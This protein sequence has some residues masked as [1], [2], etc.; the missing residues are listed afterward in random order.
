MTTGRQ[1][2]PQRVRI[3]DT[4]YKIVG[5]V[6][7][8]LAS[9]FPQKLV[10]GDYS[11][12]SHPLV[13][14]I[15]WDDWRGGMLKEVGEFPED[16]HRTYYTSL[17]TRFKGHAFLPT[18]QIS[19]P[20]VTFVDSAVQN[21]TFFDTDSTWKADG[22]VY[23]DSA[24]W[25]MRPGIA[26]KNA[27]VYRFSSA[28]TEIS[29][30][31]ANGVGGFTPTSLYADKI[32][33]VDFIAANIQG[34]F[35]H[36]DGSM[37][38]DSWISDNSAPIPMHTIRWKDLLWGVTS[39]GTIAFT[40]PAAGS[41]WDWTATTG[42]TEIQSAGNL[43]NGPQGMEVG[44]DGRL[45]VMA[46]KGIFRYDSQNERVEHVFR[47]P[48]GYN[49]DLPMYVAHTVWQG[50][51]FYARGQ[52]MWR[53]T[54]EGG[55]GQPASAVAMGLD[56]D[57]G[58]PIT[59][60]GTI[61]ALGHVTDRLIAVVSPTDTSAGIPGIYSWDEVRNAWHTWYL[62]N[63]TSSYEGKVRAGRGLYLSEDRINIP[64]SVTNTVNEFL[65]AGFAADSRSLFT[66]YVP[67]SSVATGVQHVVPPTRTDSNR[68][69]FT[70]DS[71]AEMIL[72]WV[73][74]T[75]TKHGTLL[76]LRLSTSG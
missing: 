67:E 44:P 47:V 46:T 36:R 54:P 56:G 75:G 68:F 45:Y 39:S 58:L 14:T 52:E 71:L 10:I 62:P 19:S 1:D 5:G 64:L 48:G 9:T 66:A 65:V 30:S 76:M 6:Q 40:K 55:F 15:N 20:K 74:R 72:P 43:A 26:G 60:N 73:K 3:D 12:E 61:A 4:N 28:G 22:I 63:V 53:W 24:L 49:A 38:N 37:A 27:E 25:V 33:S 13:S 32:D 21:A 2:E 51:I 35:Y 29:L 50:S 8:S 7:R 57:D 23:G 31:S 70:K 69:A 11:Q 34:V 16:Q 17:N 18:A 42:P 41:S 59:R